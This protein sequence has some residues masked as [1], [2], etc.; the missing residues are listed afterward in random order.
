[1]TLFIIFVI[2]ERGVTYLFP[3]QSQTFNAIYEG[4]DVIAQASKYC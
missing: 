2:S 4:K 3:I 1:M